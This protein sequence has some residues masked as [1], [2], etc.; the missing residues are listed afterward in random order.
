M[1]GVVA[2]L[3]VLVS[4]LVMARTVGGATAIGRGRVASPIRLQT[5]R[6]A[7]TQRGFRLLPSLFTEPD[8][9]IQDDEILARGKA[10]FIPPGGVVIYLYPYWAKRAVAPSPKRFLSPYTYRVA[11][12][13]L[14][15]DPSTHT[16]RSERQQLIAALTTLGKPV[17]V[18]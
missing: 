3:S 17:R 4:T 14:G 18:G 7:F 13:V 8:W 16:T 6:A 9:V 11:N 15:I 5:A 2:G 12:V 1:V 10:P